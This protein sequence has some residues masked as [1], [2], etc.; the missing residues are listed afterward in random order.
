MQLVFQVGEAEL[1]VE[2]AATAEAT[3]AHLVEALAGGPVAAGTGLGVGDHFLAPTLPLAS[4][5]LRQGDVVHLCSDVG[6]ARAAPPEPVAVAELRVVGGLGAG[7]RLPLDPGAHVLGRA[8]DVAVDAPTVSAR[9]A[10]LEL[11]VDGSCTVEDLGSSNGTRLEGDFVL[12]RQR[13]EP[14]QL[15]QLGA[16]QAVLGPT[17]P[18][19]AGD[20]ARPGRPGR[21]GTTTFN[22]PPR[23]AALLGP[24]PVA[25]PERPRD[26]SPGA[27]FGWAALVAPLVLGLAM[28]VVFSPVMAAFA[29]FSPVMVVANWLE[30]RRRVARERARGRQELGVGLDAFR[31]ALAEAQAA[32]AARRR[33]LLPDPAETLRRAHQP[34][35]HLWER[36]SR[37]ADALCLSLGLADV[38]WQPPVAETAGGRP[39]EAEAVLAEFTSLPRTPVEV[40]LRPGRTVGVV[41]ERAPVLALLRSLVVQAAVHHGPADLGIA[42]LASADRALDWDWAKW[43]PHSAGMRAGDHDGAHALAAALGEGGKGAATLVVVDA[44]G[45]TEGR[46]APVRDLLGREGVST[47]VVAASVDRLPSRCTTVVVM[48][49]LDGSAHC[50]DPGTSLTVEGI[51]VAGVAE[52]EARRCARALASF[53]DPEVGEEGSRLPGAVPLIP[54]LGHPTAEAVASRWRAADVG[55][56]MAATVGVGEDGPLVLDLVNDGPHGLVAG[57][58]GSGKSELLRTLVASLA[59][60]HSP[61]QL[62]FVLIDYKGGAAFADCAGLPHVVG[63]V[64]D[65]DQH[66]GERALRCL[67]AEL[68]HR[69]RQLRQAGVSDLRDYLAAGAR[70]GPLPRLLVVIDE[71]ATLAAELPDFIESL[72]GVAQRGRSLGVHLLLATQRPSGAVSDCIRANTNLRVALRVQDVP[73]STDVIGTPQAAHLDRGQA[74]RGFVR[75]GHGEVLAFQAALVTTA[76]PADASAPV[77]VRPFVLVP[78]GGGDLRATEGPSDLGRLVDA[79]RAAWRSAGMALPRR[80]WRPIRFPTTSCSTSCRRGPWGWPTSPIASARSPSPGSPATATSCSTAPAAAAPP[81]PWPHWPSPWPGPRPPIASTCTCSTT[82]PAPSPPWPGWPTRVPRSAPPS[83]SAR[84]AWCACSGPSSRVAAGPWPPAARRPGPRWCSS[85]TTS[86]PS[87]PPSTTWSGSA[88]ATS[89][90]G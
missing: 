83:A 26:P 84:S 62:T 89:W 69:E 65:L 31:R 29:L 36:R 15:L 41:G 22:R 2:V 79:A 55:S 86:A 73:D 53:D 72:V 81:R 19:G 11:A 68:E 56:S 34:S 6:P 59:A 37:H 58:T 47:I 42:V 13:L 60:G 18:G 9:H 85:P 27:R 24:A 10:R 12:G 45:L 67:E 3:V 7:V 38:P 74:G 66:L 46:R 43:L 90:S 48:E 8:G 52:P 77:R 25:A 20:V 49:G 88:F 63:L 82:A 28:A 51:L 70:G 5:G 16:V 30:D 71:F 32:E 44:E 4:A 40:D 21:L 33:A 17:G 1:E 80:P 23:L 57:T 39:A 54:L 50:F 76:T 78:D 75:L 87:T 35:T 64:T 61:E 14:G